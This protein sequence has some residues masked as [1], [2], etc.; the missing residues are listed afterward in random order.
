MLARI[1]AITSPFR[2]RALGAAVVEADADGASFHVA[3]AD[4]EHRVDAQLFG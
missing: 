3:A 4:D 2:L 1:S